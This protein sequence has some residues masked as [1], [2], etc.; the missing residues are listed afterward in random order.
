MN[1]R[2]TMESKVEDRLGQFYDRVRETGRSN[3]EQSLI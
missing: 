1:F 3:V 2:E